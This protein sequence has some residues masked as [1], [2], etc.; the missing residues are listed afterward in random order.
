MITS[1]LIQSLTSQVSISILPVILL[2]VTAISCLLFYNR[3][4]GVN[5][6]IHGIQH[7]LREGFEHASADTKRKEEQQVLFAEYQ[8]L[9]KR[10]HYLR[11]SIKLC[12]IALFLFAITALTVIAGLA[13]PVVIFLTLGLW[14]LGAIFYIIAVAN[15]FLEIHRASLQSM[16]FQ[17]EMLETWM[18][19]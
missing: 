18:K 1:T 12:F 11:R 16:H 7:D 15:A 10:S 14:T 4:A 8:V 6:V 5:G 17:T 2:P 3:L 19:A 13:W 9:L